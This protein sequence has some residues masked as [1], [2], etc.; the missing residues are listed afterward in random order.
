[1]VPSCGTWTRRT[2]LIAPIAASHRRLKPGVTEHRHPT[3]A[4]T[5]NSGGNRTMPDGSKAAR[6]IIDDREDGIFRVHR[7]VFVDPDL[8][9]RERA[10]IF[11]KSWLFAGHLSELPNP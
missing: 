3:R 10:E 7:S 11:D 5:P 6:L 4:S 1:M 8:L 9:E 2:G